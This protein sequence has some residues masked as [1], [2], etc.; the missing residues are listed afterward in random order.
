MEIITLKNGQK[1][2]CYCTFDQDIEKIKEAL[3]DVDTISDFT[4]SDN[5]YLTEIVIPDNVTYIGESAFYR[6]PNL[7]K[8]TLPKGLKFIGYNTFRYCDKLESINIPE[9][10]EKIGPYAFLGCKSLKE[11]KLPANCIVDQGAFADCGL[12]NLTIPNSNNLEP[13]CFADCK[14]LETITIEK[15]KY[16]A[17]F[18]FINCSNLKQVTLPKEML[19]IQQYAFAMCHKLEEINLPDNIK[20]IHD[21]VFSGC[22]RLAEVELPTMIEYIGKYAFNHCGIGRLKRVEVPKDCRMDNYAFDDTVKIEY[23]SSYKMINREGKKLLQGEIKEEDE[24]FIKSMVT[25]AILS[26]QMTHHEF[27]KSQ[28]LLNKIKQQRVQQEESIEL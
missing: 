9:T 24:R 15:G 11:V 21:G 20:Y 8:V 17:Q 23:L 10:V 5:K 2:I 1:W 18:E 19:N 3:K 13:K 28:A 26:S 25:K 7:T 12:V 6:C 16:L 14:N 27:L 22:L 4:F